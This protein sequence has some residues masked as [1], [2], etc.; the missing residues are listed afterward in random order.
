MKNKVIIITG[1]SQGIGRDLACAL[2]K[3]GA[4]IGLLARSEA[5][6]QQ[7]VSEMNG[8]HIAIAAD[9]CDAKAINQAFA[10]F[11]HRLGPI[12]ILINSVGIGAFGSFVDTD[13]AVFERLM[14]VNYMGALHAM[15]AVIPGMQ[16][17]KNGHI[18]HIASMAGRIGAPF[19]SAYS[20][21]K[22]ALIGLSEA[23]AVEVSPHGIQVSIV[24][25]GGVDTGF[26]NTRGHPYPH[27]NPPL[28]SSKRV[29][30]AI[31][32]TIKNRHAEKMIPVWFR[33]A[34]FRMDAYPG[35]YCR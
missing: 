27:T 29:V 28:I 34:Y 5:T 11:E 19:E 12:D 20:A 25:P 16:A 33:V 23:V 32:A 18:I 2:S 26:F 15:K 22:F 17:R 30:N 13:I 7:V 8:T 35:R 4:K 3:R 1:A 9:I 6:L 10:V 31:I 21:S 24:N 14:N